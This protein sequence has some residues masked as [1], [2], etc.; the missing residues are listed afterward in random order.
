MQSVFLFFNVPVWDFRNAE[1]LPQNLF[2]PSSVKPRMYICLHSTGLLEYPRKFGFRTILGRLR[3]IL[4]RFVVIS[5]CGA[6]EPDVPLVL[7]Q[8]R[9]EFG[10][11]HLLSPLKIWQLCALTSYKI[12]MEPPYTI[13]TPYDMHVYHNFL[14]LIDDASITSQEIVLSLCWK[15]N[16]LVLTSCVIHAYTCTSICVIHAY[17]YAVHK[18]MWRL[19]TD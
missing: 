7:L 1:T 13:V 10:A 5:H 9:T 8:L 3:S 11:A 18:C 16:C 6:I 2:Y 12:F 15:L 17:T 4:W 19:Q 14:W